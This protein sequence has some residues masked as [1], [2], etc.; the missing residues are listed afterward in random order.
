[1]T[2][3]EGQFTYLKKEELQI[4]PKLLDVFSHLSLFDVTLS[5]AA[6]SKINSDIFFSRPVFVVRGNKDRF[7]VVAGIFRLQ[8]AT[9]LID[10]HLPVVIVDSK[11]GHSYEDLMVK[12][13]LCDLL[14]SPNR[15]SLLANIHDC[16]KVGFD[17]ANT[18]SPILCPSVSIERA[19]MHLANETRQPVRGSVEKYSLF[20][21]SLQED[22]L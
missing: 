2:K 9:Y 4:H 10:K 1:M 21:R 7:W 22:S 16:L 8:L 14:L 13:T 12:S 20:K 19:V 6:A 15:K 18:M 5:P 17:Y 11:V 3:F